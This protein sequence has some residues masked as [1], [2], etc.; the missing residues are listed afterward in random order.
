MINQY[1]IS[2]TNLEELGTYWFWS[3]IVFREFERSK[4]GEVKNGE[5][6]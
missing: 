2:M 6:V 3:S 1:L 5:L 4:N